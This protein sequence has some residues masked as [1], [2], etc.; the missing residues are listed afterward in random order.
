[1]TARVEVRDK[2]MWAEADVP[3]GE[4][5]CRGLR[6]RI[7]DMTWE[8]E[9]AEQA[10]REHAEKQLQAERYRE[11]EQRIGEAMGRLDEQA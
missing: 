5:P 8:K 6:V 11:L 4:L 2:S 1:M 3:T 10:Q 7:Q 9:R